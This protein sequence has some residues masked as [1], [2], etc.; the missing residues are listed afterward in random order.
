MYVMP[1]EPSDTF[2]N[3]F[4]EFFEV[5]KVYSKNMVNKLRNK[6]LYMAGA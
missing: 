2:H 4:D 1:M 3:E 5:V 6:L